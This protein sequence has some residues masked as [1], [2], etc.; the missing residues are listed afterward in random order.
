MGPAKPRDVTRAG[1]MPCC[2]AEAADGDQNKGND[3]KKSGHFT[4]PSPAM[5]R[6]RRSM[7]LETRRSRNGIAARTF[8]RLGQDAENACDA[9]RRPC[10]DGADR[11]RAYCAAT[12]LDFWRRDR[13]PS[14]CG[15]R[16]LRF[17]AVLDHAGGDLRDVRNFDAAEAERVAG[18]HRLR[19]GAEGEARGRRERGEAKRRRPARNRRCGWCLVKKVVIVGSCWPGRRA[20]CLMVR[21][22]PERRPRPL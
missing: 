20:R 6:C 21:P 5:K 4:M 1:I 3:E 10:R 12:L 19:F 7:R 14:R 9:G 16:L 11:N 2:C 8:R 22:C 15:S 13:G 17:G 18:A